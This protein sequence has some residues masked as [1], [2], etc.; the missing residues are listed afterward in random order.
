MR[1]EMKKQGLWWADTVIDALPN[2]R[3]FWIITLSTIFY[4]VF[5]IISLTVS[6]IKWIFLEPKS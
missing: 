1:E 2:F 5:V 6:F 4:P 3:L